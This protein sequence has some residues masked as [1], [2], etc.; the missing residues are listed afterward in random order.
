MIFRE[1]MQLFFHVGFV[2][3]GMLFERTR[4]L[5]NLAFNTFDLFENEII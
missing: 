4:K 3:G 2:C 5:S 1:I